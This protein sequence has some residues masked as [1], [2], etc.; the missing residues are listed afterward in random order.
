ME[1]E[2]FEGPVENLRYIY[3]GGGALDPA[4]KRDVERA[5]VLPLHHGYGMTEYA[6]SMFVTHVDHPRADTS[7]GELAPDCEARFVGPDGEDMADRRAR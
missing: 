4:L 1:S 2:K 3:A 5:L 6:G 7:P